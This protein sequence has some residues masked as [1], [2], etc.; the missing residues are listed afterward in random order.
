M[1][2]KINFKKGY[3][4]KIMILIHQCGL[5]PYDDIRLLMG[6]SAR[7][8]QKNIR[9]LAEKGYI[10]IE[11]RGTEKII[12]LQDKEIHRAEYDTYLPAEIISYYDNHYDTSF[13]LDNLRSKN[14]SLA[15]KPIRNASTCL[16]M[17]CAGVKIGYDSNL[18]TENLL[19]DETCIYM[20]SITVK[21]LDGYTASKLK[22]I[23]KDK[24]INKYK[25]SRLTGLLV[26]PGGV[27]CVYNIGGS[28]IS[29]L[30]NGEQKMNIYVERLI[31]KRTDDSC[32]ITYQREAIIIARS[33]DLFKRICLLDYSQSN[34]RYSGT[35]LINIDYAYKKMYAVPESE[36]G[37]YMFKIMTCRN[38]KNIILQSIISKQDIENA[39]GI[40]IRCDGYD[41]DKDMAILVFCIPDMVKLKTFIIRAR[42]ENNKKRFKIFCFTHQLALVTALAGRNSVQISHMDIKKYYED[43]FVIS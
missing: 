38:W 7:M 40:D 30:R 26:S 2:N 12:R 25:S 17:Q 21:H 6:E 43:H 4:R 16:L 39:S 20:D 32:C 3:K 34:N 11:K 37:I 18:L 10:R 23:D 31:R 1:N 35:P 22:E 5:L 15:K 19:T 14:E 36:C 41:K 9:E 33:E 13:Y 42:L 29:W 27:Y 24:S 8:Y 28:M